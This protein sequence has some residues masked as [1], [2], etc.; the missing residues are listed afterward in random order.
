MLQIMHKLWISES[1]IEI[2]ASKS[3][4]HDFLG[5]SPFVFQNQTLKPLFSAMTFSSSLLYNIYKFVSRKTI[6]KDYE[7]N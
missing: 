4:L 3:Y 2:R 1:V 7:K 5:E 6:L